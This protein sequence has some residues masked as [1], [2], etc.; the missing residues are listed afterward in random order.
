MHS[1]FEKPILISVVAVTATAMTLFAQTPQ[2]P[3]GWVLTIP[4]RKLAGGPPVSPPRLPASA[5]SI[6]PATIDIVVTRGATAGRSSELRQTVSRTASRIHL[7]GAER[8][9]WLF[10]RNP[11]D[12]RRVS[13]TLIEHRAEAL[14]LYGETD[15]R[16]A[17]GIRGWADVVALGFDSTILSS[18][19]RTA[20]T[21][22]IGTVQFARY[23]AAG[24][25]DPATD[26][27]WSESHALPGQFATTERGTVTR[28]A[29][30]RLR[31]GV[32][33]SVLRQPPARFPKYR[34]VDYADWLEKH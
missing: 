27:W 28:I 31:P 17:L 30:E 10:E 6:S 25:R 8:R 9:E 22:M 16:I 34:V 13:A 2:P 11:V 24:K 1:T 23:A 5:D 7:A 33:D 12:S 18:Y 4:N 20:M 29:V 14:V 15:L 32:D 26:V 19:Q 3:D 21:R